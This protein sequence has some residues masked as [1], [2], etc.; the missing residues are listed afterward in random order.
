MS[1]MAA[2]PWC[3]AKVSKWIAHFLDDDYDQAGANEENEDDQCRPPRVTF[4]V[5]FA[6]ITQKHDAQ[7]E[8]GHEAADM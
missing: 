1:D 7:Q 6:Q 3:L 4:P 8:T 5:K 2:L